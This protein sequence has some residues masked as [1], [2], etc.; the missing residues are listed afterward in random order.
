MTNLGPLTLVPGFIDL[1]GHGGATGAYDNGLDEISTALALHR[2]HGTTRAVLSLVANPIPTLKGS[3]NTIRQIIASDPLVLGAH[4]EGPFLSHHNH[5]AHE[6]SYLIEPTRAHVDALLTAGEGVLR[7]VTIA[8]EL[9]GATDAISTRT[10]P[11]T[12]RDHGSHGPMPCSVSLLFA[13]LT[14]PSAP[15]TSP[16]AGRQVGAVVPLPTSMAPW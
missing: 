7:Q 10:T 6:P 16:Q 8:P 2:S 13:T 14:S 9:N 3:L 1:H 5:G 12:P 11:R 4:L 15:P